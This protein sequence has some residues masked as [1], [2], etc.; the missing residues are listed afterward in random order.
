MIYGAA[1]RVRHSV[2]THTYTHARA[3]IIMC[4][5]KL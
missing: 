1:T 2:S 5:Y 3:H 4:V